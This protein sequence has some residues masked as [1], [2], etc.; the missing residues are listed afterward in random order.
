[1]NALPLELANKVIGGVFAQ[2]R[3]LKLAPLAAAVLDERGCL[4]AFAVEDG[5]TGLLRGEIAQSKAYGAL[6]IGVNSRGIQHRATEAPVLVT[7]LN[8]LAQGKLL[9]AAGGVLIAGPDGMLVGAIGVSGDSSDNDEKCALAGIA[10]A[11]LRV[12]GS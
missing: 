6:A 7:S 2:A 11:G 8:T 3:S 9:P 12:P 10:A 4:K 1:M 5:A